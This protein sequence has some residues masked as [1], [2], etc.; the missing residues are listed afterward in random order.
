MDRR[1]FLSRSAGFSLMSLV[2]S[3]YGRPHQSTPG[4]SGPSTAFCFHLHGF[5][6][7][8]FHLSEEPQTLVV[9]CPI[10]HDHEY[11]MGSD[12]RNKS[13]EYIA[14]TG[15]LNFSKSFLKKGRVNSFPPELLQFSK[16]EAGVGNLKDAGH[17]LRLVLPLPDAITAIEKRDRR[18]LK[19]NPGRVGGLLKPDK[20]EFAIKIALHYTTSAP[21]FGMDPAKL[22][23]Y[24]FVTG[25]QNMH[26]Q[27]FLNHV[28][29]AL[30]ES[31][32][33]FQSPEKFDL[34]FERLPNQNGFPSGPCCDPS[35][36]VPQPTVCMLVGLN[37]S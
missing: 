8:E 5:M 22:D 24:P 33:L 31:K 4:K 10:V 27:D 35:P 12:E 21:P 18:D 23:I 15:E 20:G 32:R 14:V 1:T 11:R 34:Q 17:A 9:T 7:L 29:F 37:P 25:H 3:A 2:E 6:F 19:V 13:W 26:Q 28:N 16:K 30:E 36:P